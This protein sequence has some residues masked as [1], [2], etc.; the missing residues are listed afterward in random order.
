MGIVDPRPPIPSHHPPHTSHLK[1]NTSHLPRDFVGSVHLH[2]AESYCVWSQSGLHFSHLLYYLLQL[3]CLGSPSSPRLSY[4]CY[5]RLG[6][7][8]IKTF[9]SPDTSAQPPMY[10]QHLPVPYHRRCSLLYTLS[11]PY[12][13]SIYHPAPIFPFSLILPV[14]TP[15][16]SPLASWIASCQSFALDSYGLGASPLGFHLWDFKLPHPRSTPRSRNL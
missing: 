2:P 11:A 4:G 1:K 14:K 15:M 3:C 8:R 5:R 13:P 10:P 16:M 12:T 6:F 9:Q 7:E